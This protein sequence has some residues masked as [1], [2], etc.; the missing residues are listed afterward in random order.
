MKILGLTGGIGMGKS[1]CADLFRNRDIRLV[2]TDDLARQVVE[3]GQ[4][5]LAEIKVRFGSEY[6][7][8]AG[9]LD[10][11]RLAQLVFSNVEARTQLERILHP[12][13][14][15]LWQAE[16]KA[17]ERQGERLGVVVIPLLF[18]TRAEQDLDVTVCVACSSRTQHERLYTRGWSD[19][20]I[21]R[22]ISAQWPVF[23]KMALADFVIWSEGNIDL[24]PPQLDR[25][26][27][28]VLR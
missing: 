16:A 2:D 7:D 28:S 24:L 12:R 14:R 3:L 22:R 9:S 4:P 27:S 13:I 25:I 5:A 21:A 1:A 20:Q 10:R 11:G 17:W 18:E 8:S 15:T 19:V 23:R 6:L 26:I